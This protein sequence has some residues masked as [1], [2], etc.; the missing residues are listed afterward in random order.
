MVSGLSKWS[1]ELK[2]PTGKDDKDYIESKP[3]MCDCGYARPI[4]CDGADVASFFYD[5][6]EWVCYGCGRVLIPT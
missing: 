3:I 4:G 2:R 1:Q 6:F 5:D